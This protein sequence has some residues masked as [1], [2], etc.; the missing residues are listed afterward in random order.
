VDIGAHFGYFSIFASKNL[1]DASKILAV[2][3]ET[4]N[5]DNLRK[6][7]ALNGCDNVEPIK[8]AAGG[9][10]GRATLHKSSA[11]NHSLLS[12]YQLLDQKGSTEEIEVKTISWL[13][14]HYSLSEIDFLKLDC[15]GSEYEI[16]EKM[17]EN[18]LPRI[19]VISMEFHDLKT[20]GKAGN[21]LVA[22]LERKSF[23]VVKFNYMPSW[24]G[25]NYGR[26]IAINR[27]NFRHLK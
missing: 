16:L 8:L 18:V 1:S 23:Q 19:K 11:P 25:L 17:D 3:P 26:I 15:E 21:Q 6:N 2:E 22:L 24:Q 4:N 10:E 14:S 12:T 7:I 27:I 20:P 13:M 5:Y 9:H